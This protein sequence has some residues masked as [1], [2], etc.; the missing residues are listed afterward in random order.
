MTEAELPGPQVGPVGGGTD[1]AITAISGDGSA[2]V[3][4]S[5]ELDLSTASR[6]EQALVDELR[7]GSRTLI[8][9]LRSLDFC[10]AA[11]LRAFVRA[12][13]RAQEVGAK[14]R[15]VHPN[16]L[17]RRVLE[18]AELGGLVDPGRTELPGARGYLAS[19]NP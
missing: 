19:V 2:V 6:A 4:L 8:V 16:R 12:L 10:D 9:D 3:R 15:L 18:I 14:V 11:G 1:L 7:P 17:V 13:R 5:G